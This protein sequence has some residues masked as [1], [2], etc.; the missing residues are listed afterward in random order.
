MARNSS[1]VWPATQTSALDALRICLEMA[2]VIAL[3]I[4]AARRAGAHERSNWDT[5]DGGDPDGDALLFIVQFMAGCAGLV[6]ALV[7]VAIFEVLRRRLQ[8][9]RPAA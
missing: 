7:L 5:D 2:L 4:A 9:R 1:P 8:A 6:A 3:P